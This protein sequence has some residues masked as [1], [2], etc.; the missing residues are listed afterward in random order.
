VKPPS[1]SS[2]DLRIRIAVGAVVL[3]TLVAI[4]LGLNSYWK[5][6]AGLV[7]SYTIANLGF[8][9]VVGWSGQLA[10]AHASFFG[11]GAY[12]AAFLPQV[13][14]KSTFDPNTGTNVAE[15]TWGGSV[16]FLVALVLVPPVCA[17]IGYVLGMPAIRLKGFYLAIA[18]LAF[19]GM[20]LRVFVE[21]KDYT[22]GG[23]GINVDT[24]RL[25]GWDKSLSAYYLAL[26]IAAG[27]WVLLGRMRSTRFGRTLLAVRDT[28]IAASSL[29]VNVTQYRL[30][31]FA[32]SAGIAALGGAMWGQAVG[33]IA[34][35]AFTTA[36]LNAMLM[37]IIVGG[38][39]TRAGAAIGAVFYVAVDQFFANFPAFK[40][41]ALK[42][43]YRNIAF[44]LALMI[45]IGVLPNG[46]AALSQRL[47]AMSGR[48]SDT[49]PAEGS[50]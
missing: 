18:T 38:V 39:G 14:D 49:S 25:F 29:G 41:A 45:C 23:E 37:M 3:A 31:S 22:R 4:P 42:G 13:I 46:I 26:A 20:I 21:A 33:F 24:F 27:I 28:D 17:V 35:Q 5:F 47:R 12:A 6:L 34:P 10:M 43:A 48:S 36:L 16:P 50:A 11:I 32:I 15:Q 44:G 2:L 30:A 19:A 7:V 1:W 9:A 40:D 8:Q